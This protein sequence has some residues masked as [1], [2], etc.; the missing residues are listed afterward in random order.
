MRCNST[1]TP[2][3]IFVFTV[4]TLVILGVLGMIANIGIRDAPTDESSS[5]VITQKPSVSESESESESEAPEEFDVIE[6]SNISNINSGKAEV[7]VTAQK[8]GFYYVDYKIGFSGATYIETKGSTGL[9][10]HT[11]KNRVM[12]SSASEYSS[13]GTTVYLEKGENVVT[14]IYANAPTSFKSVRFTRITG[15]FVT[16]SL[17]S[18]ISVASSK[19]DT[20]TE[21]LSVSK[22][23]T[24]TLG[25]F[26]LLH[27]V[28][29]EGSQFKFT[30]TNGSETTEVT[31]NVAE[32]AAQLSAEGKCYDGSTATTTYIPLVDIEL[33]EGDYSVSVDI[34]NSGG[35]VINYQGIALTVAEY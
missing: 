9:L 32:I 3:K 15:E 12:T 28:L 10:S 27:S 8:A 2:Y 6:V 22:K 1:S 14:F 13:Y 29:K 35:Y 16:A 18:N 20:Y 30:I 7:V 17:H 5:A 4:F 33:S 23:Q 34:I 31:V 26:T 24:Y 11:A 19:N 25:A 21:S